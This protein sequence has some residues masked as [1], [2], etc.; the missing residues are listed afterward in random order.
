MNFKTKTSL[1]LSAAAL[2]VLSA[3]GSD[4]S[5]SKPNAPED[6]PPVP[7]DSTNV[8]DSIS[9]TKKSTSDTQDFAQRD[10]ERESTLTGK[11]SKENTQT[12]VNK[13]TKSGN[14]GV[15]TSQQ[16]LESEL[17]LRKYD[18]LSVVFEDCD[19]VLCLNIY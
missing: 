8:T 9:N 7:A 15:T 16:M 14:I 3:C 11:N 5:S 1:T 12:R 19:S 4:S 2:L 18:L 6:L 17:E 13:H 10:N